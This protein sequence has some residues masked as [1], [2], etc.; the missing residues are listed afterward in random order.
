MERGSGAESLAIAEHWAAPVIPAAFHADA[1]LPVRCSMVNFDSDA[2]YFYWTFDRLGDLEQG[3]SRYAFDGSVWKVD[4]ISSY[5]VG[6]GHLTFDSPAEW[7]KG[8]PPAEFQRNSRGHYEHRSEGVVYDAV[9]A[10]TQN[11]IVLTGRWTETDFGK[12]VF[13]A[14]LPIERRSAILL[15]TAA[16]VPVESH[17][18]Q[19]FSHP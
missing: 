9:R 10:D 12:G 14:V 15:E 2:P 13:V 8:L 4:M 6:D 19:M 18:P 1:K 5:D 17:A 7:A 11:H 16:S 3:H